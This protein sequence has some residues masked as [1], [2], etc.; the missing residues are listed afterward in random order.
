MSYYITSM[1]DDI[2]VCRRRSQFPDFP[3]EEVNLT[4]QMTP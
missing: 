4:A 1:P 2:V 3:A